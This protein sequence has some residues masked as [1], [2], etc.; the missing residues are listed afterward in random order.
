MRAYFAVACHTE[1]ATDLN[2][3]WRRV[4]EGEVDTP[5]A[6]TRMYRLGRSEAGAGASRLESRL[7][8]ARLTR[9]CRAS[10]GTARTARPTENCFYRSE[11]DF[12]EVRPVG[13]SQFMLWSDLIA[14]SGKRGF[15]ARFLRSKTHI[16]K[17]V[18]GRDLAAAAAYDYFECSREGFERKYG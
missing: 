11:L 13:K 14:D 5:N 9:R 1:V 18:I 2:A 10:A 3:L 17:I 12:F 8:Y 15:I 7:C 16:E 4:R 6:G